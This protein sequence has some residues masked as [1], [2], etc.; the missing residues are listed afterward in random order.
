MVFDA[1]TGRIYLLR[2][3]GVIFIYWKALYSDVQEGVSASAVIWRT[4]WPAQGPGEEM[5]LCTSPVGGQCGTQIMQPSRARY[6]CM[7]VYPLK[8]HDYR[9]NYGVCLLIA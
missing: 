7:F 5:L 6:Y 2:C 4:L 1:E 3:L 9:P 8:P